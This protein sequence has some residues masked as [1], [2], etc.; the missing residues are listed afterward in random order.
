MRYDFLDI[1]VVYHNCQPGRPAAWYSMVE[2]CMHICRFDMNLYRLFD[3]NT[4]YPRIDEFS[5]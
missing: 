2:V 1:S 5:N 3:A 4:K